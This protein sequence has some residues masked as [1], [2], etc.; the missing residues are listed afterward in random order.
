MISDLKSNE[1]DSIVG[2]WIW[3][4]TSPRFSPPFKMLV[5]RQCNNHQ[6]S[7]HGSAINY[8]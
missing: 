4:V 6:D 2:G 3:V 5:S 7:P 8:L 1:A